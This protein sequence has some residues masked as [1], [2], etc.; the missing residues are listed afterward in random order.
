MRLP[1]R[2]TLRHE[3]AFLRTGVSAVAGCDEVGRGALCG[4]VT[5]AMV[6]VTADSSAA[7]SG[8]RDSKLLAEADRERLAEQIKAWCT[9]W[10]VGHASAAEID[11]VGIMAALRR[12]GWR[13]WENLG[14]APEVVLLDGN[15][16]YL[17]Q[18]QMVP[19]GR[20]APQVATRVKADLVC[21]SVA[22]ASILAKTTRDALMRQLAEDF[23]AY[24]WSRNKGYASAEHRAALTRWGPT[25]VHRRSWR[26]PA[27]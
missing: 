15:H 17:R 8:V 23:P 5:V 4:P 13:A 10:A 26:L 2:P 18:P 25:E 21:S 11:E 9:A 20:R 19:H 7:P 16:D 22:A 14:V 27:G 3:R 6:V 24:G 1:V 12:A